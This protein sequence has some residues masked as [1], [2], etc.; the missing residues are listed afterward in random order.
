[1][2]PPAQTLGLGIGY[3]TLLDPSHTFGACP[4]TLTSLMAWVFPE[5]LG[6]KWSERRGP[7]FEAELALL[8]IDGVKKSMGPDRVAELALI[9]PKR[10][11]RI[12]ANGQSATQSKERK[13]RHTNGLEKKVQTL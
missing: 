7:G 1:M 4:R 6:K 11:K 3:P 12:L 2:N 5:T 9:D 10:A 13:I 8:G